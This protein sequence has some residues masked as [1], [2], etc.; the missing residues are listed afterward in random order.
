ERIEKLKKK[1]RE[2][3]RKGGIKKEVPK[4]G[5]GIKKPADM[6]KEAPKEEMLEK[7]EEKLLESEGKIIEDK[8]EGPKSVDD[9]R[10]LII[11]ERKISFK[12]AISRLGVTD[13]VL[14]RWVSALEDEGIIKIHYQFL[15]GKE[16][17]LTLDALKKIKQRQEENKVRKVRE[18]LEK[19]RQEQNVRKGTI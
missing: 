16:I 6:I 3:K 19:I 11:D 10:N 12:N 17:R 5:K 14:D 2:R 9:L 1:L 18:E 15:G 7:E 4:T 8:K 13:D